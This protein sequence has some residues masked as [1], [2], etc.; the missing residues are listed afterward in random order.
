MVARQLEVELGSRGLLLTPDDRAAAEV[1]AARR[2]A[3]LLSWA[4]RQCYQV[5]PRVALEFESERTSG[6][7]EAA[8]A[9]GAAAARV[10]APDAHDVR[11]PVASAEPVCALFNLGIGLVDGVC[12]HDPEAGAALLG[13]VQDLDVGSAAER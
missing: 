13:L 6:R 1:G 2:G 10:L 5:S 9:F 8:L 4:V 7:L 12:D 3:W 11:R